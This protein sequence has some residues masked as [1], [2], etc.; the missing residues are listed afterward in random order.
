MYEPHGELTRTYSASRFLSLSFSFPLSVCLRAPDG[1]CILSN[2]ADNMLRVYNL[3]AEL[4]SGS[5]ALLSEMVSLWTIAVSS[6]IL[7]PGFYLD[8]EPNKSV[9][10]DDMQVDAILVMSGWNFL[11]S[12]G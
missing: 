8:L 3:P 10:I 7:L 2:S 12:G 4:Y 5:W 9:S 1:S 11:L 6:F